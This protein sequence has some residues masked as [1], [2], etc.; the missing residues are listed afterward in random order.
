MQTLIGGAWNQMSETSYKTVVDEQ[1]RL[2]VRNHYEIRTVYLIARSRI[3]RLS[4]RSHRAAR[5][6]QRRSR[7]PRLSRRSHRAARR[8]QR[9]SR[10]ATKRAATR[11]RGRPFL[12][13]RA[14]GFRN[15][16]RSQCSSFLLPLVRCK[17][18]PCERIP[19]KCIPGDRAQPD[20][21]RGAVKVCQLE[22]CSTC[23]EA[24]NQQPKAL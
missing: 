12:T 18:I 16:G 22:T 19:C 10:V 13:R 17:R 23:E 14:E 3:P 2:D 9:Q 21:L 5:R 6:C 24:E 8:C 11:L 4:R 7:I 15:L 20:L 1:I